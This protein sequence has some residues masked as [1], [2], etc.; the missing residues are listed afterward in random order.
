MRV[1]ILGCSG[2]IGGDRHTTSMLVDDDILIDA[3]SGVG[4][5]SLDEM[6]GIRHLFLTH[7]HLDHIMMLPTLLDSVG[8]ERDTPLEVHALPG[9]IDILKAHLFNWK[10]WPDFAKVPTEAHPFMRY[11][12]LEIGQAIK[13][14]EREIVA[15][16]VCHGVPAAG[17]LLRGR[18]A[19][20]LFSGDTA[21]HAGLYDLANA[22]PD[23]RHFI[24]ETSFTSDQQALAEVSNHYCPATLL[25]D[26]A[27]LQAGVSVW[28][29]HLKPG[30]EEAIMA[31][32]TDSELLS[33]KPR[34]LAE[35]Q[36]FEL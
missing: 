28:I 22:T 5:L 12:P 26:L 27:R 14:G 24:V 16:P 4:R 17:Y 19:S 23:L 20:L 21:S 13:L 2:G 8:V 18:Q 36:V 34:A 33:G 32:L 31:E 9:V 11:V 7:A 25:P 35:N 10:L 29:T 3:G 15:A 1:R 30:G 6:A